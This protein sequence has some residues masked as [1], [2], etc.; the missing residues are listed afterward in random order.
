MVKVLLPRVMVTQAVRPSDLPSLVDLAAL[1]LTPMSRSPVPMDLPLPTVLLLH[2]AQFPRD[3]LLPVVRPP[4]LHPS[5][6]LPLL[7]SKAYA[8]LLSNARLVPLLLPLLSLL[9]RVLWAPLQ[10]YL[11]SLPRNWL[12]RP[13]WSRS[14]CSAKLFI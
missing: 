11:S 1:L 6:V 4:P 12:L 2:A 10:M 13:Q 5:T 9:L 3:P 7:L 14:R 8:F